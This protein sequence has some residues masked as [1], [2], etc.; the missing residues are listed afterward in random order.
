MD[1]R[2]L[3]VVDVAAARPQISLVAV[4]RLADRQR[5]TLVGNVAGLA[6]R[7]LSRRVDGLPIGEDRAPVAR[8]QIVGDR[9]PLYPVGA[10]AVGRADAPGPGAGVAAI[11]EPDARAYRGP[12]WF[13][14]R[15]ETAAGCGRFEA[16]SARLGHGSGVR[17]MSVAAECSSRE[18]QEAL[19]RYSA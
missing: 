4:E 19:E 1:A 11:A 7:K 17:R 14:A 9:N 16:R 3:R 5:S 18:S 15:R 6:A 2:A 13:L 10:V 8:L 12:I